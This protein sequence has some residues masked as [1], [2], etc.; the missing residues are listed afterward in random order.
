MSAVLDR[1][2]PHPHRGDVIAAG[3]VPLALAAIVIELRMSQWPLGAR[4]A[5]VGLIALLLLTMGWLAPLEGDAPRV[6][7]SVLL[8]CGLAPLIVALVLLAE[9]MGASRPPGAGGL[10]WVF[11][12]EAVVA[13]ASARRFNSGVCTLVAAVAAAVAVEA[14]VIWVF[15]PHGLGTFRA[16]LLLL[17]LGFAAGAT[18][19]RDHR[20]RHAVQLVNAAGIAALALAA[21]YAVE[22]SAVTT[23]SSGPGGVVQRTVQHGRELPFGWALY[24]LAVG[25][26]S[27][28]YACAD[29]EAGPAYLGTAVL[30][31]FAVL[32]GMPTTGRGSLVGWPLFLLVIGAA[33]LIIGLRPR[34]ELPP[35]P[36][37][38]VPAPTVPLHP[39]GDEDG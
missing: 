18:Q 21:T 35:P 16:I 22:T 2:R 30:L 28:A 1:L 38:G 34:R 19:L 36:G 7:H 31:A 24:L 5:V 20:R 23:V 17:T 32:V 26:G 9:I 10:C 33:G 13:G 11:A 6:Y 29:R 37:P 39:A 4:F 27:V 3:A 8:I 25:F 12:A 15:K 14:F